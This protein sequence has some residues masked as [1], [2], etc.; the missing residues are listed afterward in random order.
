MGDVIVAI[1]PTLSFNYYK[2]A[3]DKMNKNIQEL[4][5]FNSCLQ[6][7]LLINI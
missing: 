5:H 4:L 2:K 7:I 3:S 6:G 1:D